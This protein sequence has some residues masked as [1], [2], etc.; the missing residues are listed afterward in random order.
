MEA[1]ELLELMKTR[2]SYRQFEDRQIK[3]EELDMILEAGMYAPNAGGRQS[4]LFLVTQDKEVND[5]LGKINR[6]AAIIVK[7]RYVNKAQP[8]IIDNPNIKSGFY[9]APT[10]ITL[11]GPKNFIYS[12]A[13]TAVAAENM[14]LMAHSLGIGGCMIARAGET[15]DS[16]YGRALLESKGI[17]PVYRGFYH[18]LL[19]Y[20]VGKTYV[21]PRRERVVKGD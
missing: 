20:P 5:Q 12:E 19:G 1:K 15:M 10:V 6:S 21:K 14:L 9:G 4:T 18:V 7:G 13:D 2:R 8:S 16:E 11:L 3:Q 17:D